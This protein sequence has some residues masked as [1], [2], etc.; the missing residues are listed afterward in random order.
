M[1]AL[2]DGQ[3][4]VGRTLAAEASTT[5]GSENERVG[6]AWSQMTLGT[7]ELEEGHYEAAHS[8]FPHELKVA[9]ELG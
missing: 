6:R 9:L 1:L 2:C 3:C 4:A 7:V 8:R 5:F